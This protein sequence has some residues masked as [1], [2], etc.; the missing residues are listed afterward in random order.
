MRASF[1]SHLKIRTKLLFIVGLS[2]LSLAVAAALSG[3]FL[4][5]RML[6]DRIETARA[7]VES[8][9]GVAAKL[10]AQVQAGK[11][12]HDEALARFRQVVYGARYGKGGQDYLMTF[13]TKGI[14]IAN[15][16]VPSQEGQDRSGSQ[17]KLGHFIVRDIIAAA[18]RGGGTTRY[19]YPKPGGT[20]PLPKVTYAASFAPW[21]MVIASGLYIDDVQSDLI[22]MLVKLGVGL[23]VLAG[24]GAALTYGVG[25]SI[26]RALSGLRDK[27]ALLA[28]G[29]T[30]VAIVETAWQDEIG[31]MAR[32]VEVFKRNAIEK[33]RLEAEREAATAAEREREAEA[34]AA[35]QRRSEEAAAKEREAASRRRD[36]MLKLADLF[37]SSVKSVV[38][39]VSAS[40]GEMQAATGELA[41]TAGE[42]SRQ[43]G[44][45]AA[46]SEQTSANVQTVA[47]ATEELSASIGE[48]GR[49]VTQSTQ[50]AEKA[51]AEAQH[52]SEQVKSLAEAAQKI[53]E[54][55]NLIN[56]IAAQTNLLALNATI[57]AAR[58]GE[59]GK[60][61]AVVASEVKTLATQTAK[62]T[63]EI[64]AQI[65]GMQ[66]AT[67]STVTAI[68][69]I[70]G[71]IGEISHV[72]MTI[73]SAIEEQGA[74]TQ[75]IARNV[76]QAARG[77]Q[78]VSAN[79]GGVT[80]AAATT[81]AATA[82][83]QQATSRLAEQSERLA[84][85]VDRFLATV[86][87]A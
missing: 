49:Q 8:V 78:D 20:E 18:E 12:S 25:R 4:Y 56:D 16:N 24:L 55:V 87:A 76:Q 39:T 82:R 10:E 69:H 51:V 75:E 57:E 77:T 23:V 5:E 46:A 48:I 63:E 71:T 36:E 59:A 29:R 64:A 13:T 15:G 7:V 53:G 85:E 86:R 45:V 33:E 42:T 31:E 73:A 60:G 70:R 43:A 17:D 3:Y 28:Q 6:D 19:Y 84:A 35:E 26:T 47:T 74:A 9:R 34:R 30:E 37:E 62:A 66:Q 22:D 83:M 27:M 50:I 14:S 58:A 80:K 67:G 52:T 72:A 11:L 21:D 2:V 54:V 41:S 65:A 40:A 44:A 81:G 1:L 79:I 32:A 38:A 68:D 61:F